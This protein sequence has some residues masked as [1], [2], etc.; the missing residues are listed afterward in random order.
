MKHY[1]LLALI[2]VLLL[3]LSISAQTIEDGVLSGCMGLSGRYVVPD[4]VTKIDNFAFFSSSVT[5]VVIG[6]NVQEISNA[7]FQNCMNLERVT[8]AAGSQ[9]EY[10]GIVALVNNGMRQFSFPGNDK[11]WLEEGS[12][13]YRATTNE[14]DQIVFM[15]PPQRSRSWVSIYPPYDYMSTQRLCK[16]I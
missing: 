6:K 7:A 9:L 1:Y 13:Y 14:G 11:Y 4:E 12:L 16:S 5:E 8:F 10:I 2:G 15:A 3:P